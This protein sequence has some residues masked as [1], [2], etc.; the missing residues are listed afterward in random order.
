[1]P[2]PTP[3]HPTI[4]TVMGTYLAAADQTVPGLVEG[5]YLYGSA[6]L[7]DFRDGSSDIDFAAVT[8]E[9]PTAEQAAALRHVHERVAARHPRQILDGVYVTW[10]ELAADPARAEPG[11]RVHEHGF[12]E[13][14]ASE[15]HLVIWHTLAQSGVALR[16]PST[17]DVKILTD[18]DGL[19]AWVLANIDAYWIP[20]WRRMSRLASAHGLA[21]LSAQQT[22]WSVL[23]ATRMH[24]TLATGRI[25]SKSAAGEYALDTFER[26]WH[27]IVEEALRLRTGA[28]PPRYRS[29]VAR[30]SDMLAYV[31]MVLCDAKA[32]G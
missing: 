19:D 10:A 14:A 1:M 22:T 18:P 2:D 15:R 20:L 24:Y 21:A 12:E 30:R 7:D 32:L 23:G 31:D 3:P 25:G 16:G 17:S 29:A 6:A 28:G 5:L 8:A 4:Q 9:K 27:R 13:W 26:R 11:P